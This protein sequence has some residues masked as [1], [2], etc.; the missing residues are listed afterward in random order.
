[1]GEIFITCKS[2]LDC[3]FRSKDG[4]CFAHQISCK[5]KKVNLVEQF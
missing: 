5:N 4:A 1:M 2:K 3:Y